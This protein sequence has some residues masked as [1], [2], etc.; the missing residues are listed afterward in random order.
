[1]INKLCM[2]ALIY[3][4]FMMI[5][6]TIDLYYSLYNMVIIKICIGTIGTLLLNILCQNNMSVISW[7]I[8]SI[9]FIM[10]TVIATFILV[11][12]GLD[13]ATGKNIKVSKN[14]PST[15][16]S[17]YATPISVSAPLTSSNTTQTTQPTNQITNYYGV[18]ANNL[19]PAQS[20]Y[21]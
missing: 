13:P 15:I 7:L 5:H 20:N 4:V 3:L 18:L 2:P 16:P 19:P 12:L 10:M 9:P 1:M 8:V 21:T 11:V 6:I 14:S 17:I